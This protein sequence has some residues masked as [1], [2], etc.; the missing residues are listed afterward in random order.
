MAHSQAFSNNSSA[1]LF[2]KLHDVGQFSSFK[3]NVLRHAGGYGCGQAGKALQNGRSN[4]PIPPSKEAMLVDAHGLITD[5]QLFEH[6][7]SVATKDFI[8]VGDG[9]KE[10]KAAVLRFPKEVQVYNVGNDK[11]CHLIMSHLGV[12]C[13][14]GATNYLPFMTA[15]EGE[16]TDTFEMMVQLE[17]LYGKGTGRSVNAQ[18]YSFLTLK[19]GN[20]SF[21][22]FM[23]QFLEH[24]DITT[25]NF[26]SPL[27]PGFM[28]I[29][30]FACA[31]FLCA[32]EPVFFKSKLDN[33]FAANPSGR[34]IDLHTLLTEYQLYAREQRSTSTAPSEY[35]VSM[36]A[37]RSV[38]SGLSSSTPP[39]TRKCVDCKVPLTGFALH[40]KHCQRC[41][42]C[43]QLHSSLKPGPIVSKPTKSAVLS[44]RS[45]VVAPV[46]TNSVYDDC[47]TDSD[48]DV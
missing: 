27:H 24:L 8:F 1:A 34:D 43:H 12:D 20:L 13:L 2:G 14:A 6:S 21:P 26:G 44:S 38:P 45:Y 46:D 47:T 10:Y 25:A 28:S 7:G 15:Y 42:A 11:L 40:H 17:N 39:V 18:L 29:N 23:E 22:V 48:I 19:Q 35:A 31:V 4:M 5:I 33:F 32:I 9:L 37:S 3:K 30:D 41:P 16:I 36:V